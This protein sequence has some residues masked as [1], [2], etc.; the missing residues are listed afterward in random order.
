MDAMGPP[1]CPACM[2]EGYDHKLYCSKVTV[3]RVAMERQRVEN[4]RRKRQVRTSANSSSLSSRAFSFLTWIIITLLMFSIGTITTFF[5][6]PGSERQRS[7]EFASLAKI[8]VDSITTTNSGSSSKENSGSSSSSSVRH[9]DQWKGIK[10][11]QDLTSYTDNGGGS[12]SSSSS[13]GGNHNKA[14][15]I[16][17][18]KQHGINLR[19]TPLEGEDFHFVH[20]PKCGG[21]S[22]TTVL[23]QVSRF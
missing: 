17:T 19:K 12:S 3:F 11:M 22:M 9:Q 16:A 5:V 13:G 10:T 4:V 2:H 20:I 21:T 8:N 23:R 14:S 15:E 18:R 7:A 6:A 1:G